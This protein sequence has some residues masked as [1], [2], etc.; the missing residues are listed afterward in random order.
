MFVLINTKEKTISHNLERS[1]DDDSNGDENVVRIPY[2]KWVLS[3]KRAMEAVQYCLGYFQ[4]VK[5]RAFL[6][7]ELLNNVFRGSKRYKKKTLSI[8]KWL[9]KKRFLQV[10]PEDQDI[11]IISTYEM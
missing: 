9:V 3:P 11:N 10:V 7:E 8:M 2:K 1:F 4:G 5:N 6:V